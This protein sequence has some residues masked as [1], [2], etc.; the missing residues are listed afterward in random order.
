MLRSMKIPCVLMRGGTSK[1]P[2]F[3]ASDL[4]QPVSRRDAFLL[5]A[6]GSGQEL[7]IDGVGGGNPLSSKVAIVSPSAR[8]DADVEYLFAQVHVTKPIVDTSPNCGNMLSGVGPF[9]IERGLFPADEGTTVVRIFNV[10][11]G[12]IVEATIQTP[13]RRVTYE[14]N[15][16]IDGVPGTAAPIF[17]T[18]LDAAGAK[19]GKLLPTGRP[20]ESI[21][22]VE[23]TCVD[24][25]M[26]LV[27]VR[28]G[29]LGRNIHDTPAALDAD[30]AFL[31]RLEAIRLAA[32]KA[33]GLGDVGGLVIPK[34]VL[35]GPGG[36]ATS[37]G[38]RYF[39]PH[40]CHKAVA[41][42][43]SVGIAT[44]SVTPGTLAAELVGDMRLPAT[45]TIEHPS[46][47]LELHVECREGD[48]AP[49][50]SLVRTARRLF[51]GSVFGRV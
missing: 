7:E 39:L 27:L 34:P 36:G 43:G 35:I 48:A 51:E 12:K 33:M 6:L 2:F 30:R 21:L 19:T 1:G 18:F 29:D 31:E 44:A 10:N 45:L 49:R 22:G 16:H 41:V 8:P 32:G 15:T 9:A 13:D 46:G 4:P 37:I 40:A 26:P 3:L 24:A 17:L 47:T 20:R 50:V 28:A 11:T 38:V 23:V 14:G 42:T 25:A 5:S